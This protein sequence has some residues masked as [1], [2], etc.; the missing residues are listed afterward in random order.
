MNKFWDLFEQSIITQAVLTVLLVGTTCYMFIAGRAVPTLLE[1][2]TNTVVG[3]WIGSKIGF[4]QGTRKTL[5]NI[6]KVGKNGKR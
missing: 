3:F 4:A 6:E 5:A 1:F 2:L